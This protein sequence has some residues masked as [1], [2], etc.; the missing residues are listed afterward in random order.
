MRIK[1][2]H[3]IDDLANDLAAIPAMA[4]R[5]MRSAVGDAADYGNRIAQANARGTSGAHGKHYPR[6]FT[7]DAPRGTGGAGFSAEYGPVAGRPQGGMSFE[8]GSRNQRPH[9]DLAKSKDAAAARL[10]SNV[11]GAIPGWFWT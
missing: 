9:L 6:A 5:D 10:A 8:F 3:D 1:V 2:T 4:A 7:A 11:R